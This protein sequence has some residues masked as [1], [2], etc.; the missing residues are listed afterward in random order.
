M[1]PVNTVSTNYIYGGW[2]GHISYS[3]PHQGWK[4][5]ISAIYEDYQIVLN[6]VAFLS[7]KFNFS[8]KYASSK[9]LIDSLLDIHG[10]RTSGG[11]LI[12]IYPQNEHHCYQLL[13][14]LQTTG[15]WFGSL[16]PEGAG[17]AGSLPGDVYSLTEVGR[18]PC[19]AARR[20]RSSW[21]PGRVGSALHP[22]L[23]T[24]P[25]LPHWTSR[26]QDCRV[27]L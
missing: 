5:H 6:H 15:L 26:V 27:W 11:K 13:C 22:Q 24:N 17:E 18:P 19:V 12:T 1:Y 4:I 16:V 14:T 9:N 25:G 3:L 20:G 8:F 2:S 10:D 21:V 23:P 7:K